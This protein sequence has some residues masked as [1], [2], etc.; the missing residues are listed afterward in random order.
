MTEEKLVYLIG[1]RLPKVGLVMT[2]SL[3]MIPRFRSK[4]NEMKEART[5]LGLHL[6]K[7]Y[8][9]RVKEALKLFSALITQA[10][11]SAIETGMSMSA[12]GYGLKR[13]TTMSL[14]K[15][16][17]FDA[18]FLSVNVLTLVSIV[19]LI[20][21]GALDFTFYPTVSHVSAGSN[22]TV[23]FIL[24]AIQSAYLLMLEVKEEISWKFSRSKI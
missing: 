24:F 9:A 3:R 14:Y 12:R 1:K 5:T 13:R 8:V 2:V 11:E 6:E 10:M 16:R 17:P 18:V 23:V 7:G 21:L 20:A 19:S 22:A 4:W 15:F